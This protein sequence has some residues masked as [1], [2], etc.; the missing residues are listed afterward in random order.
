MTKPPG[1]CEAGNTDRRRVG[2]ATHVLGMEDQVP[3]QI[4]QVQLLPDP[5]FYTGENG[6][7]DP[8]FKTVQEFNGR[9]HKLR[10][11]Y[12][13][14]IVTTDFAGKFPVLVEL[15]HGDVY[16]LRTLNRVGEYSPP[17][18]CD[19]DLIPCEHV[20]KYFNVYSNAEVGNPHTSKDSMQTT[21]A[22]AKPLGILTIT[23]TDGEVTTSFEKV[24]Q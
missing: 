17:I 10:G 8:R 12:P 6:M 2:N 3:S 22:L 16:T 1:Q 11:G 9:P 24:S 13:F 19:N 21:F 23:I 14:R 4:K 7:L 15:F 5:L 20:T 18:G